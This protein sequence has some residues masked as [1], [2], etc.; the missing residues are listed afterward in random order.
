MNKNK[1]NYNKLIDSELVELLKL[2]DKTAF[3]EIYRR[4]R[5][6]L[7]IH[8]NNMVREQDYAQDVVHEVFT[9]IY[10]NAQT[11]QI[12]STLAAYLYT[13]VRNKV[14]TAI[15]KKKTRVNY[16]TS[17]AE[18]KLPAGKSTDQNVLLKELTDI[19]ES[20]I[21]KMPPRMKEIFELS[22]KEYLPHKEIAELL[23]ISE[24]TVNVQIQRAIKALRKNKN[25]HL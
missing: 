17:I 3:S 2:G 11:M 9:W 4:Y 10:Q 23:G 22:R 18:Y 13:A 5:T 7:I 1:Q 6:L 12:K 20:E 14:L 19:I 21:D 8:V 16:L 15:A 25:I 24:N